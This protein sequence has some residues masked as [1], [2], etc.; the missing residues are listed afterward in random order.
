MENIADSVAC[1]AGMLFAIGLVVA[2][3]LAAARCD[4][5]GC[6]VE[7]EG[8]YDYDYGEAHDV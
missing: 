2:L 6:P 8:A 5:G 4:S 1:C 3:V 7:S